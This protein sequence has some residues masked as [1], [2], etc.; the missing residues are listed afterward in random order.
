MT[1]RLLTRVVDIRSRPGVG[2]VRATV[3]PRTGCREVTVH[4]IDADT[5]DEE[6]PVPAHLVPLLN[7]CWSPAAVRAVLAGGA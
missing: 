7:D 2:T 4:L 3:N 1:A 5:P 6:L